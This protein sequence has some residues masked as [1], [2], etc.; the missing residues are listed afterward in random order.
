MVAYNI[1]HSNGTAL[2]TIPNGQIDT[3]STSLSLIGANSSNFGQAIDQNLVYLLENFASATSPPNPNIGQTWYDSIN[4]R[5]KIYKGADIWGIVEP[6]FDGASGT[7]TVKLG[8]ANIDVTLILGQNLIVCVVSSQR[9][10]ASDL[11]AQVIIDDQAYDL[12]ASFPT[13]I[14]PGIT[15]VSGFTMQGNASTA[16][17]LATASNITISGD[18]TGSAM[19]DGSSNIV[20]SSNLAATGVTAGTYSNVTVDATGRVISGNNIPSFT[21]SQQNLDAIGWQILPGKLLLQ[22]GT[23]NISV[24]GSDYTYTGNIT[25]G[26]AFGSTPF[27]VVGTPQTVASIEWVPVTCQ[28]GAFN[29]SGASVVGGSANSSQLITI[30]PII[31]WYAIGLAP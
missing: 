9:I 25:F 28:I 16:S 30:N 10:L 23:A 19:F 5:L 7:T 22:W 12:A 11:A 18:I 1:R 31:S 6:P 3:L 20:I 2:V 29:T 26:T 15:L 4:S 17:K 13:G 14:W 8:P 24:S 21:G 27:V